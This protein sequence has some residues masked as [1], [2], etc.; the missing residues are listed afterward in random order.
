MSESDGRASITGYISS[1]DT[2]QR[3]TAKE[4]DPE[5]GF[6]FFEARY[7]ASTQGR[8][9]SPDPLLSSGRIYDSQTWNRY[10]YTLNNPLRYIDP[11]GLYNFAAGVNP[12][13]QE[14]FE[15]ALAQLQEARDYF[16]KNG[17]KAKAQALTNILN[18]YGTAN[19][20]NG[21]TV[22]VGKVAKG[23]KAE[24]AFGNR[25]PRQTSVGCGG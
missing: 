24:T 9:V 16:A 11:L 21:V 14:K 5:T 25:C 17:D 19:D 1:D 6:D 2:R 8:F 3:F 4:R 13:D 7:Y 18:A 12:K 15:N 10:A 20:G 23:A 22:A